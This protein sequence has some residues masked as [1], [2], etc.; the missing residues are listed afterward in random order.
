MV[1]HIKCLHQS[2]VHEPIKTI[3]LSNISV[4]KTRKLQSLSN[5]L[6]IEHVNYRLNDNALLKIADMFLVNQYAVSQSDNN[7][8]MLETRFQ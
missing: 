5:V 7:N 1:P 4:Y 2:Q 6:Y 3:N 8:M